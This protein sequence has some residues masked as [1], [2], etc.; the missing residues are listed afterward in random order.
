MH[1]Q[2]VSSQLGE[3]RVAQRIDD[4]VEMGLE[5]RQQRDVGDVAGRH[6]QQPPWRVRQQVNVPEIA[7]LGDHH[8]ALTVGQF[9]DSPARHTATV[10]NIRSMH[11]IMARLTEEAGKACWQLGVNQKRHAAVSGITRPPPATSAPNSSAASRS[12]RSRSG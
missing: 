3:I 10:R 12:S 7:I 5:Q 1:D 6:D 11:G 4:R 8:P 9:G 2:G